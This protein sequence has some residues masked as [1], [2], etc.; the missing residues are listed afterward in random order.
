MLFLSPFFVLWDDTGLTKDHGPRTSP[1]PFAIATNALNHFAY[2]RYAVQRP[3]QNCYPIPRLYYPTCL[4]ITQQTV[5][6][7]QVTQA[8]SLFL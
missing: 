3:L 8:S 1:C 6:N 5:C 2:A 7:I 4:L